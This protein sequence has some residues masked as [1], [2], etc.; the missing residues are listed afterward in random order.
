MNNPITFD[1]SDLKAACA[2][3]ARVVEKRSA[4]HI[5]HNV[6]FDGRGNVIATDLDIELTYHLDGEF[7]H[8]PFTVELAQLAKVIKGAARGGLVKMS[9]DAES[10]AVSILSD[11]LESN[12][13]SLP[14][15]DMP[16]WHKRDGAAHCFDM[17]ESELHGALSFVAP[18]M[19]DEQTRYYL[20]GVHLTQYRGALTMVST[21]G[22]QLAKIETGHPLTSD[23]DSPMGE[24]R[25]VIMPDKAVKIA[26]ATIG[27][28]PSDSL[29]AVKVQEL[30][31]T[32]GARKW[33]MRCK[34][35]D[36][37]F[38]D[39]TRIMPKESGAWAELGRVDLLKAT[40]RLAGVCEHPAL[41][42]K[43]DADSA[44]L[45]SDGG[46]R[47]MPVK[48]R[49]GVEAVEI[50]FDHKY[51]TSACKAFDED[52]LHI[53]VSGAGNPAV[54]TLGGDRT[55]LRVVMPMRY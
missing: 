26:L 20:R 44:T 7:N 54:F 18:C 2:M 27:A 46:K 25:G 34:P 14:A 12:E 35:V 13:E 28:K 15:T 41:Q 21:D 8:A 47:A 6:L 32:I 22:H 49:A 9:Y 37:S 5:L 38:P 40:T 11:G 24:G 23:D 17:T 33:S 43:C 30:N 16:E 4:I 55:R 1:L 48:T 31:I 3:L 10:G 50:A 36:G 52:T 53:S 29:I 19:S 45:S 39:W 51:L 42:L